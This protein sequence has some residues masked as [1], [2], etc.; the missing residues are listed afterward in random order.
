MKQRKVQ[1]NATHE[2]NVVLKIANIRSPPVREAAAAPRI[3]QFIRTQRVNQAV[4]E[5]IKRLCSV[6]KIEYR[7]EFADGAAPAEKPA[8]PA[9][10]KP[11]AAEQ[12]EK[13]LKGL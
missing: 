5:E 13:G 3:R 9:E 11:S 4:A 8:A 12:H 2:R 6:A 10:T 1:V 7:G